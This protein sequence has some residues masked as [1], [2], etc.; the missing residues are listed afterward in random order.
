MNGTFD[1][2]LPSASSTR[3][4]GSLSTMAKVL[5]SIAFSSP[6]AFISSWPKRVARA[7]ALDRGDAVLGGDRRAVAPFQAVAQ[8]D[9]PGQLVVGDRV[10]LRHLRLDLEVGVLGE[11]HVVDHVAE[12]SGDQR[13]GPDRVEDLDVGVAHHAQRRLR[14]PS[15]G[16]RPANPHITAATA[17]RFPPTDHEPPL[18]LANFRCCVRIEAMSMP[19]VFVS[20]GSPMLYPR[21]GR[22]GARLPGDA[23]ASSCRGPRRSSRCRRIG[24]PSGRPSRPLRGPRRSTISTA[25]PTRSIALRYDAPGAPELAER[26]AKLTGAAID[27]TYGLDHGAWVPAM[28]GWPE[29]DIPIFQ[30]SV[31]PYATPAAPYRARPQARAVARGGRA[32][33]G[34]RQRHPQSAPPG[35]RPARDAARA[36]GQGVRRLGGGDDREGRRGGAGELSHARRRMPRT[37][38]RPTSTS[39]RC[40]S[41]SARQAKARADAP[42]H[43]SFT[44][45]NLSMASYVFA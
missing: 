41:P 26:V 7:P 32:G 21:E 43:R 8:G 36:M 2:S 34:Q 24:T 39:C 25:F 28:L 12:V 40:M 33:D 13:R 6:V 31:Q 10:L 38:I 29:A 3:P 14:R 20:H 16:S 30:L 27:P 42:L 45:G 17:A 35:A 15:H 22:A 44:S 19:T 11:Q 5:A 37:P 18:C 9:G 4:N 1:E 23:R